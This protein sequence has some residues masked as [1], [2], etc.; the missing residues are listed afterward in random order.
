MFNK[1]R[2]FVSRVLR[3]LF[4]PKWE[5][6]TGEW[7]RLNIEALNGLV[8]SPNIVRVIK[9]RIMRWAGHVVRTG[10]SR[11]LYRFWWENLREG[12]TWK[13]EE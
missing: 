1:A 3:K 12:T 2:V 4:G 6:V 9:S 5:E 11:V 10:E 8:C 7:T 13:T